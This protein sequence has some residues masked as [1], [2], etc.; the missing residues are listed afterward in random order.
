MSSLRYLFLYLFFLA[1]IPT[2]GSAQ[3]WRADFSREGKPAEYWRYD[4]DSYTVSGAALHLTAPHS[5]AQGTATLVCNVPLP[6]QVI[7]RGQVEM[8]LFPSANNY[9]TLLLCAIRPLDATS[10]EYI[11]LTFGQSGDQRICLRRMKVSKS[12]TTP[13]QLRLTPLAPPLIASSVVLNAS[14]RRW[15]Y[16]VRYSPEG[17]WQLA[18]RDVGIQADLEFIGEEDRYLPN[19][20]EKNTFGIH[21]SYT[22]THH[23]G[24]HFRGLSISSDTE[25]SD[26]QPED[27]TDPSLLP[28]PTPPTGAKAGLLLS[29]VMPHPKPD[30]PEYIE[31]YNAS[32]TSCDLA[33]YILATGR[34]GSFRATPLPI[35]HISS[36]SYIVL[37]KDPDALAATYPKAPRETFVQVDLPR[38]LNQTGVIGLLTKEEFVLDLLHY[39]N[40]LRPKGMKNKAGIALE[41]INYQVQEE[42]GNWHTASREAGFA[43][44][45]EK[46]SLPEAPTGEEAKKPKQRISAEE[47]FSLLDNDPEGTCTFVLYRLTGELL[48]RGTSLARNSWI[49][50]LRT[51]PAEALRSIGIRSRTPLVLHIQL[52][53]S[54]KTQ[55]ETSLL[56]Q[57]IGQ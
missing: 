38:L 40:A 8:D 15:D 3:V 31:L 16:E 20:P 45:G 57:L 55:T 12:S 39:S 35:H 7:W 37:T 29:E 30:S 14:G 49:Q 32:D 25:D 36:R 47:L 4:R 53:R 54:D 42:A 10:Y 13:H 22:S 1:F 26:A 11:A 56:F 46:N 51:M 33:D 2:F 43:T 19:L 50:N 48:A 52:I 21:C 9:A 44:P 34:N 23:E 27:P 18:L 24:W 6:R 41:R 28:T 17:G 5:P